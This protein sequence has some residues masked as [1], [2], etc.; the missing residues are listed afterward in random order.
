M[1]QIIRKN[2]DKIK[3]FLLFTLSIISL[4]LLTVVFKN[5]TRIAD[6]KKKIYFQHPDYVSLKKFL[7]SKLILHLSS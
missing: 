2:K 7:L 3:Y 1:Y 4:L 6:N 5:D